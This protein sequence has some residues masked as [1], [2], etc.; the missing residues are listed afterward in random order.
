MD[1]VPI[2]DVSKDSHSLP[3]LAEMTEKPQPCRASVQVPQQG[4]HTGHGPG[5]I[6]ACPSSPSHARPR[7][8]GSTTPPLAPARAGG[9]CDPGG[10]LECSL[11]SGVDQRGEK[12][13]KN[14]AKHSCLSEKSP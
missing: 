11:E 1:H 8:P 5:S 7:S 13:D 3:S 14:R 2:R 12:Q 10:S 9:Y 6:P 4:L